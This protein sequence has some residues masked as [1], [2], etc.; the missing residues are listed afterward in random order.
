M[1]LNAGMQRQ[2]GAIA[3]AYSRRRFVDVRSDAPFNCRSS[4]DDFPGGLR[5]NDRMLGLLPTSPR[6]AEQGPRHRVLRAS[7]RRHRRA[8]GGSPTLRSIRSKRAAGTTKLSCRLTRRGMLKLDKPTFAWPV[9]C[10]DFFGVNPAPPFGVP[11][12]LAGIGCSAPRESRANP[13]R[14]G[15]VLPNH[16]YTAHLPCL[17]LPT[18]GTRLVPSKAGSPW[19]DS[20][21][22]TP[23]SPQTHHPR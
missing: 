20:A 9:R 18:C 22:R 7:V 14:P 4:S 16:A 15:G 21:Q 23:S 6:Y 10:R 19:R 5:M 17:G 8:Q 1:V 13:G 2:V 11:V 3:D 12:R